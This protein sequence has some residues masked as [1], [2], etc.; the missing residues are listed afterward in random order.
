MS[1]KFLTDT[2]KDNFK[3][4]AENIA[5]GQ[6]ISEAINNTQNTQVNILNKYSLYKYSKDSIAG[7]EYIS[8]FLQDESVTDI[9]INNDGK[10]WIDCDTGIKMTGKTLSTTQVKEIAIKLATICNKRLDES[11][12]I[13]DGTLPNGIRFN[14]ILDPISTNGTSI[15][16]RIKPKTVLPFDEVFS[17]DAP[18][19]QL[20]KIL[21]QIVKSKISFIV[22]GGTGTGKT[23]LVSTLSEL[24][25]E[26]E[27]VLFIEEV[28][29]LLTNHKNSVFLQ[30][31]AKNIEDKGEISLSQLVHTAMRMR[32]DRII[33]GECRGKEI[34]DLLNAFNTGHE[35]GICTIHAN[36]VKE[37]PSR[38]LSLGILAKL[39][40]ET[41]TQQS[42]SAIKIAIHLSR[43]EKEN[44]IH[45]WISEIGVFSIENNRLIC[46]PCINISQEGKVTFTNDW[47]KLKELINY[48][49]NND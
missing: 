33:L 47:K 29:E 37:L 1:I 26:K 9:M 3:K 49:E 8:D 15:S 13:V 45:R 48:A 22:S 41:I 5:K 27:R 24:F 40:V 16:L 2:Q 28:S 44:K 31:R 6:S 32:P 46:S 7:I 4:I 38:I 21:R 39:D 25:D 11:C 30:A 14:A 12:P 17:I 19:F 20:K 23:T 36:S 42:L 34:A 43:K 35:G 10:I 18:H